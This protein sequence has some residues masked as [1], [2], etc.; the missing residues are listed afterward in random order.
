M[1]ARIALLTAIFALPAL[2]ALAAP[3]GAC[4]TNGA[5][6]SYFFAAEAANGRRE[7]GT[8]A[9]GATL[10]SKAEQAQG[11]VVSV[12]ETAEHLEG[13][14][15]LVASGAPE[16]MLRYADFDRCLWSSNAN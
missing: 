13:C 14:S 15:R 9:P 12:F 2:P 6:E 8:L 11:G 16:T 1:T 5:E 7:T 4:V 3:T 10:C